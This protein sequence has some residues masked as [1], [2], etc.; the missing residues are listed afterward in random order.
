MRFYR[1]LLH[2]YPRSFRREYGDDMVA[3]LR[4]QLRDESVARVAART[5][6][7]LAITVPTRHLEAHMSPTPATVLV[8]LF[9]ALAAALTVFGGPVGVAGGVVLLALAVVTWRRNRPIVETGDTRWWKLLLAG[10]ALLGTLVVVTTITGELHNG[11][12]YLAM[13]TMLTS[14]GLIGAGIVLGIAGRVGTR[15]A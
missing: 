6:V 14:F 7:D 1:L 3:L 9:G 11:L 5:A 4:H 13:A 15:P 8:V 12:W 10:V 2:A